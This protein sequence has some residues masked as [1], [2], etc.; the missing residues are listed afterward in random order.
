MVEASYP[1]RLRQGYS[2]LTYVKDIPVDDLKIDKSFID[3]LGKT[4]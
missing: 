3:G 2:S 4:W 1:R